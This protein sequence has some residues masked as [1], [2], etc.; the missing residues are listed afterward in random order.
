M[1]WCRLHG[2]DTCVALFLGECVG[3][4][5]EVRGSE[6]AALEAADEEVTCIMA[7]P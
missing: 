1:V 2:Y 4:R 3:D 6:G 5:V 7:A